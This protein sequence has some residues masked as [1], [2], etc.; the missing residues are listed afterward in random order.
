MRLFLISFFV[1]FTFVTSSSLFAQKAEKN[2]CK[3]SCD[4][5]EKCTLLRYPNASQDQLKQ[6][7]QGCLNGCKKNA[8]AVD[9]CFKPLKSVTTPNVAQC[10][11]YHSCIIS[12]YQQSG[13]K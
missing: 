8:S 13:K 12:A 11:T 1:L 6:F 10:T 7:K 3:A 5:Y 4:V 9:A 2:S